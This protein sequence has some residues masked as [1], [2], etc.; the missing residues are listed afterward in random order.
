M[1]DGSTSNQPAALPLA[2]FRE[3]PA[4]MGSRLPATFTGSENQAA[5]PERLGL[6]R[7]GQGRLIVD[8]VLPLSE[9]ARGARVSGPSRHPGESA[10]D[11]SGSGSRTARQFRFIACRFDAAGM[12]LKQPQACEGKA[13]QGEV[14]IRLVLWQQGPVQGTVVDLALGISLDAVCCADAYCAVD[15]AAASCLL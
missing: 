13:K 2:G 6:V 9:A 12:F 8:Q 11:P 1:N 3:Q 7:A 14:M 4:A 15:R 5:M 10:V